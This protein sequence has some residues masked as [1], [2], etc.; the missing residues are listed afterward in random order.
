MFFVGDVLQ[1][2][3]G[4]QALATIRKNMIASEAGRKILAERPVIDNA[5]FSPSKFLESDPNSFGYC[6]AMFMEEHGYNA[7]DRDEVKFVDDDE[8]AYVMLRYRQAWLHS[9]LERISCLGFTSSIRRPMISST[10]SWAY[11]PLFWASLV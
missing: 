6:Y 2:V 11:L 10:C 1:C 9:C 7:D 3:L 5:T 8:L 4:T